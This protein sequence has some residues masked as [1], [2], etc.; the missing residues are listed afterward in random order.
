MKRKA[1]C[2]LLILGLVLSGLPL[3]GSHAASYETGV[4][5]ADGVAFRKG[6]SSDSGRIRRLQ[7]GTVVEILATNVNA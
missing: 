2:L 3:D 4:I 5:N 1:L 6:A 7:K